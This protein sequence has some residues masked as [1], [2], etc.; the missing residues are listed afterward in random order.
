[1]FLIINEL[2]LCFNFIDVCR[3][4]KEESQCNCLNYKIEILIIGTSKVKRFM[5]GPSLKLLIFKGIQ[6]PDIN[7]SKKTAYFLTR[8]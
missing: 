2:L 6:L 5:E 7:T 4:G 1:M 8:R 3:M